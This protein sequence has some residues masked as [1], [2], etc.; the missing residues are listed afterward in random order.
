MISTET[1]QVPGAPRQVPL[2]GARNFRDLGG[3]STASGQTTW[4]RLYRADALGRLSED[5]IA[6]LLKRGLA[7]VVDLRYEREVLAH[8]D[9]FER[10]ATVRYEH[11]PVLLEDIASGAVAE[12]MRTL[13]LAAHNIAMIKQSAQ[14]FTNLFRLLGQPSAYPLVFHCAGGRDRTGVAAAL[15]LMAAGVPRDEIVQDYLL[16]NGYL[17]GLMDEMSE[18]FRKQG[19]DPEP[20]IANLELR[21]DYLV[22]MLDVLEQEYGGIDAYLQGI[23]MTT[24]ELATFRS[25]FL[26]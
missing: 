11:N 17:V 10:H 3:Y 25:Q 12:R 9:V 16:S 5:D 21:E 13:D 18:T 1:R 23:G 20:I 2:T 24:E 19:I 4:G 8:P 22:P 14:T 6:E 15:V 7:T 26:A